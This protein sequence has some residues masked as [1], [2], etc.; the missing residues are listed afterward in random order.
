MKTKILIGNWKMNKTIQETIG[1]VCAVKETIKDIEPEQIM[2]GIAPSFLALPVLEKITDKIFSVAQNVHYEEKGAYTGETSVEMLKEIEIDYA[3]IG[4][5][6]RRKYFNESNESC[7]LKLKALEKNQMI[8]V[9]CVGETIEEYRD[10]KT[11]AVIKTQLIEGLKDLSKEFIENI[12]IAYEPVWAIGT[13]ESANEDIA[14]DIANYI[15]EVIKEEFK[16]KYFDNLKVLYGGS[17]KPEN[18]NDYVNKDDIDGALV[19]GASLSPDSFVAM[20][21]KL[22]E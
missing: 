13:G 21:E 19:G 18:I 10:G 8:A 14:Q 7:N 2:I 15:K 1:F 12:I 3:L 20:I 17:V 16:M 22:K 5:S 9:Y 4:H 6:E 11:K